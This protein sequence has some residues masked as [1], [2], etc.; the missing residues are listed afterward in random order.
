MKSTI[1]IATLAIIASQAIT[2]LHTMHAISAMRAEVDDTNTV[3][4]QCA[5]WVIPCNV[6]DSILETARYEL[7]GGD[8]SLLDPHELCDYDSFLEANP[9]IARALRVK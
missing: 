8:M 7:A 9:G 1:T 2:H 4:R 5:E 6:P 3:T